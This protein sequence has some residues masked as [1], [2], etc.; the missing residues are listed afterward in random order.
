[1]ITDKSSDQDLSM[2]R[3]NKRLTLEDRK[4]IQELLHSGMKHDDICA[5][6]GIWRTTFYREMKRCKESYCAEEAHK[7]VSRNKNLLDWGIIGKRFGLLVVQYY[8]NVYKKRTWWKCKCDCGN[9]C[10]MSRKIL[11][12]RCSNRRKL[13]CGCIAKQWGGQKKKLPLGE[14]ALRK[15]Q[16]MMKFRK[17]VND[18]WEWT[19]YYQR[20]KVAKTSW[21]NKAMTVRKCMHLLM[22]GLEEESDAVFTTCGNLRCFNPDH[23]TTERPKKRHF[24]DYKNDICQLNEAS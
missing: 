14:L 18:C 19:G 4:R 7:T 6:V 13:S 2:T 1:V 5:D 11:V 10:I 16:D 8:A 12:E 20:G 3:K 23:I 22:N 24:F 15:Y 9:T 21:R 17:I